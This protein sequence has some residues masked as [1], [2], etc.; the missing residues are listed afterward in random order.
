MGMQRKE[1]AMKFML[2]MNAPRNAYT[3]MGPWQHSD[4]VGHIAYMR[5]FA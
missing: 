2:M 4:L 3:H 1:T 5:S